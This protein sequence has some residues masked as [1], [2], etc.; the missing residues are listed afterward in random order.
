ME[1]N[2]GNQF[3]ETLWLELHAAITAQFEGGQG[4]Y[5]EQ[6]ER[7][8]EVV[9]SITDFPNGKINSDYW[10]DYAEHAEPHR[11][12]AFWYGLL[13]GAW[14]AGKGVRIRQ[15]VLDFEKQ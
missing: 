13:F 6:F 3:F 15:N 9:F 11:F 8:F 2:T 14:L 4:T 12:Y 5:S 10:K 7:A 1:V